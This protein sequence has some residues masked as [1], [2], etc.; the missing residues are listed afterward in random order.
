MKMSRKF[1]IIAA[2]LG[3]GIVVASSACSVDGITPVSEQQSLT[4]N[5]PLLSATGVNTNGTTASMELGGLADGT[6]TFAINPQVDQVV[7]LGQN[8]VVL[9]ANSVCAIGTSGYASSLW[10]NG[11]NPQ[12]K[13][14]NLKVTVAGSGTDNAGVDFQPAMRFNPTKT[15]TMYMYVPSLDPATP[16]SWTIFYCPTPDGKPG[17]SLGTAQMRQDP[18]CVDESLTDPSL[19]VGADY[20][21]HLLFRRLKH[22]SAYQIERGGFLVGE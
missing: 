9:P 7:T 18:N 1:R 21:N 15:V 19:K 8:R 11:C 3:G 10:D 4:P 13:A 2:I 17:R 16:Y 22:F 14:F 12:K 5:A 20:P 6:Y